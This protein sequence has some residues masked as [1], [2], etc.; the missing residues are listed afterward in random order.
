MIHPATLA[1]LIAQYRDKQSSDEP[2]SLP[3]RP[4]PKRLDR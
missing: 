3:R 4:S 1:A 2:T